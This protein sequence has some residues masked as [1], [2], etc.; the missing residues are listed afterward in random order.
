MLAEALRLKS[1]HSYCRP[2][3]KI[4]AAALQLAEWSAECKAPSVSAA[5]IQA[6]PLSKQQC[7]LRSR[8]RW[9]NSVLLFHGVVSLNSSREGAW[10]IHTQSLAVWI[11]L[12][13]LLESSQFVQ[14]CANAEALSSVQARMVCMSQP[15]ISTLPSLQDTQWVFMPWP[16]CYIDKVEFA[17]FTSCLVCWKQS[18][19]CNASD[20]TN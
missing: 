16:R 20:T 5:V 18:S 8:Q 19:G 12:P 4:W 11:R 1:L 10:Q 14:S 6:Q 13:N 15:R 7:C 9:A 17:G 2:R 3:D